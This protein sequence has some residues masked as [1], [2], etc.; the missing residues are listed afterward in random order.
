[1][2]YR[3]LKR[4]F[5]IDATQLSVRPYVA[6]YVRWGMFLPFVLA[7]AGLAWWAYDSG[8]EFAGFHRGQT[9]QE[10]Q[11][12]HTQV[13]TLSQENIALNSKVAQYEQQIQINQASNLEIAKQ[14]KNLND[15]NAHLREDLAFFQNLTET[16]G[17]EGELAIHRLRLEHDSMPGEYR[18]RMLLVQSGQRA[19]QFVGSYQLVAT[20]LDNGQRTTQIFPATGEVDAQFKLNFKY[21][22]RIEQ[23]LHLPAA[24]QLESVQ[25][26]VFELD[27]REPKVRQNVSPA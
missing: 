24:V 26:R 14:L 22:Q 12:L 8:L 11:Q 18:V 13:T 4:K 3:K 15:E 10:L 25:V 17:K 2:M 27:A 19:K 16:R 1:M 7:A 6:W 20:V 9:Q 23:T 21:Y 5:S